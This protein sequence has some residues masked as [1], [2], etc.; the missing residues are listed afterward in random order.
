VDFK[1]FL[2]ES[3][4]TSGGAWDLEMALLFSTLRT[5]PPKKPY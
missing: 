5:G 1:D 4:V 2:R 3:T